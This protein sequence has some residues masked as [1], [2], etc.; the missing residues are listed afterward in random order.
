MH[1]QAGRPES[2]NVI[3]VSASTRHV[4]RSFQIRESTLEIADSF[5]I[6]SIVALHGNIQVFW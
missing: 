2:V 3:C 6:E 4:G 5:F 1:V